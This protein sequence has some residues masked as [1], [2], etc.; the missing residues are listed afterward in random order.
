MDSMRYKLCKYF[1]NPLYEGK[2]LQYEYD[3]G[4]GWEHSI[5][6]IGRAPSTNNWFTCADGEGH[7]PSEDVGGPHGWQKL[8]EAYR[9]ETPDREQLSMSRPGSM[10]LGR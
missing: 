9:N 2:I 6:L 4:D 7:V 3:F 1:E 8:K 5:T 10:S